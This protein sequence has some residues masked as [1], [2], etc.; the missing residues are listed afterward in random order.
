MPVPLLDE[1]LHLVVD[2]RIAE[3]GLEQEA[4]ELRLGQRKR[5]L[6]LDRVLRR[7]EQERVV[8][9]ARVPVDGDLLLGHRLE[10]RGLRLRHR[11]I[12]LVDEYDIREDRP[13][14]EL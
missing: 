8:E 3:R 11:A 6:V 7:E 5:S 2:A 10:Q 1:D 14:A 9:L 13:R 12:D 4:V